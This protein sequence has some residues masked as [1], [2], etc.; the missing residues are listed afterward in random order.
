[1]L[2]ISQHEA[3]AGEGHVLRQRHLGQALLAITWHQLAQLAR[4]VLVR[5]APL[6]F[7]GGLEI[8]ALQLAIR[9]VVDL[10]HTRRPSRSYKSATYSYQNPSIGR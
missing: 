7:A 9:T 5:I 8:D 4:H 1:M 2:R 10:R 6:L 3:M